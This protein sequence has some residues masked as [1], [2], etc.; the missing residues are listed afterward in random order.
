MHFADV[1]LC[2]ADG[3]VFDVGSAARENHDTRVP[4]TRRHNQIILQRFAISS[5]R[6]PPSRLY[7]RLHL[8]SRA[9]TNETS[10]SV[11]Q[12]FIR[13]VFKYHE[14]MASIRGSQVYQLPNAS[15]RKI[16]QNH[17]GHDHGSHHLKKQVR[18]LRI[19]R[20]CCNICRHDFLLKWKLR[21][22]QTHANHNN[23]WIVSTVHV[24]GLWQ[25]HLKLAK[26]NFPNLRHNKYSNDV[27]RESLQYAFH[28]IVAVRSRWIYGGI[29]VLIGASKVP[30]RLRDSFD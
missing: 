26:W 4:W 10:C 1:L 22:N 15:A 16:L 21:P 19:C 2:W 7:H 18:V 17:S 13:F 11:I 28:C 8:F 30:C 14:C 27:R 29:S 23:Y 12:I 25:L 5:F 20:G 24:H 9:T 6:K 3:V